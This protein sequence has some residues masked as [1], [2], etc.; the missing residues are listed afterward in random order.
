M[1]YYETINGHDEE[2]ILILSIDWLDWIKNRLFF[3]NLY[4]T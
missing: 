2:S 3:F 4:L 1:S